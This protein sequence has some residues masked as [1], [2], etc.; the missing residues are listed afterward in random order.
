MPFDSPHRDRLVAAAKPPCRARS[1]PSASARAPTCAPPMSMRGPR[2]G[3]LVTAQLP[4]AQLSF[5][6]AQPGAALGGQFA[7]GAGR[8]PGGRRRS[9]AGRPRAR[10]AW[11]AEGPRRAP[12]DRGRRRRG[13]ADRRKLQRQSGL[14]GG[15]ARR[16]S[17][18]RRSAAA[19]SPC[20][21][22]CASWAR[23]AAPF[24]PRWPS[25]SRRRGVDYAI[26]VGD[27]DGARSRKRLAGRSKSAHVPDAAT[28]I[29]ACARGDRRPATRC[30]SRDRTRSDLPPSSRRWR[31]GRD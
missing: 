1:S 16:C 21:A 3:S 6:I 9:R 25:R 28:A 4:G 12:P 2:G 22:R 13:A 18:T 27:G 7:G 30:S 24:T 23:T 29:P 31:A 14:D 17:A 26:L 8:G 10:R 20:S 5:T 11:R 19:A 15:D